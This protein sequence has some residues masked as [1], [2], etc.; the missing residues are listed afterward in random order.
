[1]SLYVPSAPG[2]DD[3]DIAQAPY[4]GGEF[5]VYLTHKPATLIG[6]VQLT[7]SNTGTWTDN[8]ATG[9]T[10][11][12]ASDL[13]LVA[14][15]PLLSAVLC[16]VKLAGLD[17][18]GTPVAMNGT[19]TF[20]PPVRAAN[21]SFNFARGFAVDLV[22][23]VTGKKFSDITGLVASAPITGG[24]NN[25]KF[26]LYA[27]PLLTDYTLIGCTTDVNFNSKSRMP[28]GIDCGMEADAFVKRGKT[29]PG[30]LSIGSKLKGMG[31]SLQ[32]FD[33]AKCTAMLVGLK[34]GQFTESRMVF[35]Q[36]VPSVKVKLPD[37]DGEAMG[38]A[39][40]KYVECLFFVAP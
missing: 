37:G 10:L 27:L 36:Y 16:I 18:T 12:T 19:A 28:K 21:Q 25:V 39:D 7:A 9:L 13:Q 14:T 38:D 1:M 17:D 11:A 24:Q 29:Q 20:S 4:F 5:A 15:S 40:G 26:A 22:P 33:G 32:R 34:D 23:A 6:E 8:A 35:T 3:L 30:E 2:T 31:E